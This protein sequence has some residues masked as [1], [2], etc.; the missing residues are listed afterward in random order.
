MPTSTVQKQDEGVQLFSGTLTATATGSEQ[1]I[2]RPTA[3]L[4]LL[5]EVTAAA[6]AVGDTLDVVVQTRVNDVWLDICHFTQILGNGGAQNIVAKIAGDGTQA[7]YATSSA[8]AAGN[9]RNILGDGYRIVSTIVNSS[10]PSFTFTV[11]IVPIGA[12]I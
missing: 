11:T 10:S 2:R 7:M 3:G 4:V 5:L 6:T 1:K 9:V 12:A 8:L